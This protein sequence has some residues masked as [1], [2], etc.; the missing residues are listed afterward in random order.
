M[1]ISRV[2][3]S[4]DSH[5]LVTVGYG[6]DTVR[7]WDLTAAD[8]VDTSVILRGHEGAII[9]IAIS[10]DS[11]WIITGSGDKTARRWTL[12]LDELIDLACHTAGR[13]LSRQEW[14]QYFSGEDYRQTCPPLPHHYSVRQKDGK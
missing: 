12:W 6:A 8:P 3:I 1:L 4:P 2:E 5:W 7:L 13:N 10:S 9:S 11:H 14:G